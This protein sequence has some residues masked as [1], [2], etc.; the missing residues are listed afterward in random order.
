MLSGWR[1]LQSAAIIEDVKP[2]LRG[3]STTL[4]WALLASVIV[5]AGIVAATFPGSARTGAPPIAP[6]VLIAT[7]APAPIATPE[8]VVAVTPAPS[9]FAVPAEAL[10]MPPAPPPVPAAPQAAAARPGGPDR[11]LAPLDV[12]AMPLADRNRLGDLMS[13]QLAEFPV[14]VDRPVRLDDRIVAR[15]PPAALRAGRE[16]SVAVWI[17]VDAQGLAEEIH[18][19][20]GDE[21]FVEAVVA[22]LREARFLPAQDKLRP[23]RYPL[24]LEF[25]FRL[26]GSATAV[27]R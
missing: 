13:R 18:A 8:P 26:G 20:E 16:G 3:T 12:I 15:Y 19:A 23:I 10:P 5:H 7:L 4:S 1:S 27:A 2:L 11:S 24:A 9:T 17:V 6:S 14:E 25:D 21:D 22:A